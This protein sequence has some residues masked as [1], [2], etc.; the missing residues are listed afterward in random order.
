LTFYTIS[1]KFQT[2]ISS[3]NHLICSSELA[4]TLDRQTVEI[5]L[6]NQLGYERVAMGSVAAFARCF[7]FLP[8]RI[9][10][11]KTAV[12]EACINA[13]QHG[14]KGRPDARVVITMSFGDNVLNISVLDEGDGFKQAPKD[15]DIVRIM[16]NLDPPVGFGV[17]LM[18]KLMDEFDY[19]KLPD[20]RNE[21][22]MAMRLGK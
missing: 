4:K 17:F 22:R 5:I 2:S 6:P 18:R 11:L 13:V 12:A 14:N 20:H 9:E 21:V 8:D 16:N 19:K 3:D 15:P 7:G 1:P 10:D